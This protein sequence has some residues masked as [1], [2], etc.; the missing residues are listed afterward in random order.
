M[1]VVHSA[2]LV[3]EY[4]HLIEDTQHLPVG[5]VDF[6]KISP[7]VLEESAISDDMLA[8][9]CTT[10]YTPLSNHRPSSLPSSCINFCLYNGINAKYFFTYLLSLIPC[11]STLVLHVLFNVIK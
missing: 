10:L 9:V 6:E 4:L 2:A 8:P 1:C 5:C 3:A 7:N 11:T